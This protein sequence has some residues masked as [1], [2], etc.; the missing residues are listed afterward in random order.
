MIKYIIYIP[1]IGTM[2]NEIKFGILFAAIVAFAAGSFATVLD[3]IIQDA[4]AQKPDTPPGQN[5][6]GLFP[7]QGQ[8]PGQ[9]GQQGPPQPGQTGNQGNQG[10]HGQPGGTGPPPGK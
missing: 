2:K 3:D 6:P 1:K 8:G 7:G 9:G 4:S 10:P 5:P